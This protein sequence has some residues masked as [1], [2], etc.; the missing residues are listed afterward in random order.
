[1]RNLLL[2]FLL[3]AQLPAPCLTF[4]SNIALEFNSQNVS[5][6]VANKIRLSPQPIYIKLQALQE[7]SVIF[8]ESIPQSFQDH[9]ASIDVSVLA[10]FISS[11]AGSINLYMDDVGNLWLAVNYTFKEGD[12]L[13]TL[14]WVSSETSNENL[15]IPDSVLF[16]ESYPDDV[17]PFLD[18]GR[19][20]PVNDTTIK[21][22]AESL[23]T[24]DMI[25]TIENILNFLN[26]T[27]TYDRD[28]I[29]LLWSGNFNTTDILD[30]FNDPIESLET[31]NSFCFER[32]LLAATMLRAVGVPTR[33]F[34]ISTSKTWIQVWLPDIGW[35]DAEVLCDQPRESFFPRSLSYI[36]PW[37]VE[38][39]S[40]AMFPFTWFPK[41]LMRVAANLTF[42]ELEAFNINE[43][44]TVLS[45]PVEEEL[46]ETDPDKFSFPI[47]FEPK[48]LQAALT[49]NGSD[50]IFHLSSEEK[51]TSKT[52]ILGE[53]NRIEF[54]GFGLSFKPISQ[55]D[56]VILTNFSVYKLWVF[57]IRI[58]IPLVVAV[59]AILIYWLYRKRRKIKP[60][61]P[62]TSSSL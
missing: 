41:N 54:E 20:M 36:V 16:P 52:L 5:F 21:E 4:Q 3:L 27:Q 29:R 45:Q 25:E 2:I 30:F 26:E 22:I 1:L 59:P 15:T 56:T 13:G 18:F 9:V 33:T 40:D 32:A 46:Y 53:T 43:Y 12:Y 42:S 19:K 39:S 35:V 62:L 57:D 48:I 58:L 51:N 55:G 31:G 38:N 7:G 49:W 61:Q 37:M 14:A 28:K 23:A 24:Q 8:W 10:V 60:S 44:G 6:K 34:T 11:N 17:K 47:V 50:I